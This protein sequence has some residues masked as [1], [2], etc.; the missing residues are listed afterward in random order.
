MLFACLGSVRCSHHN[1]FMAAKRRQRSVMSLR[2]AVWHYYSIAGDR[3]MHTHGQML[4]ETEY[5]LGTR[6]AELAR[7]GL[8]HRLWSG[9]AFDCRERAGIGQGASVLDLGCGPGYTSLD[10]V[11]LVAPTGR[12]VAID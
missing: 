5:F 11:A 6:A 10:L 4:Q 9:S 12:V 7:L 3:T 8:Q 1:S 2:V